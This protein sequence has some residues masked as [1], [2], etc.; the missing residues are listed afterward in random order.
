MFKTKQ[1]THL[2]PTA[3]IYYAW[4]LLPKV[5]RSFAFVTKYLNQEPSSRVGDSVMVFYHICRVLDTIEDSD[6]QAHQKKNLYREFLHDLETQGKESKLFQNPTGLSNNSGYIELIQ[7]SDRIISAYNTLDPPTQKVIKRYATEM[8]EG[9]LQFDRTEIM[10]FGDLDQYC[11]PVA[12]IIGYALTELFFQN[13]HL[14]DTGPERMKK[15]HDFG[16]ALQKVNIIRDF[17][18]DVAH[19]IY[20]WPKNLLAAHNLTFDSLVAL[21]KNDA[22][23]QALDEMILNCQKNMSHSMAYFLQIPRSQDKIRMFCGI[24]LVLAL[25]TLTK[26]KGNPD[27]FKPNP[28]SSPLKSLKIS[29]TSFLGMVRTLKKHI[30]N[31]D[32]FIDLFGSYNNLIFQHKKEKVPWR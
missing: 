4:Q 27:V 31:D 28:S 24:S 17:G 15:G 20:F 5:S 3:D 32:Y 16:L 1:K 13:G 22:G 19:Q 14:P 6:R 29:R 2:G 30:R 18:Q 8:A 12:G 11:H 26:V 23:L 25:A 10:D 9:M 7:N 21:P